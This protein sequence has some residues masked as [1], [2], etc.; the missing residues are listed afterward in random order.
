MD[1]TRLSLPFH[2]VKRF[3][4]IK[5]LKRKIS[6]LQ[7]HITKQNKII[8]EF[9]HNTKTTKINEQE[10]EIQKLNDENKRLALIIEDM[11]KKYKSRNT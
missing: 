5:N 11:K 3:S 6:D 2:E 7:T 4:L 8:E 10:V 1:N 9:K